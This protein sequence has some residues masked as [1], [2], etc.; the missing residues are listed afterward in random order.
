MFTE[1]WFQVLPG[2]DITWQLKWKGHYVKSI[3]SQW[4]Q[5]TDLRHDTCFSW[6]CQMVS[7]WL[8]QEC[9]FHFS[10]KKVSNGISPVM[11]IC[12]CQALCYQK[13]WEWS[14]Y[15]LHHTEFVSLGKHM[16]MCVGELIYMYMDTYTIHMCYTYNMSLASA[17]ILSRHMSGGSCPTSTLLQ[18][19]IIKAREGHLGQGHGKQ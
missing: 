5:I 13:E 19:E 7:F 10:L 18:G 12:R 17:W 4:P 16:Y 1:H 3:Q 2:L 6:A 8:I 15:G 11:Y 9:R 14:G